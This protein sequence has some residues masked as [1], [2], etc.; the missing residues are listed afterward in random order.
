MKIAIVGTGIAGLG[1]AHLLHPGHDIAVFERNGYPG[2]HTNTIAV[3]E[4]GREVPIDTGFMVFNPVTYPRL[5]RLF[6]ELGVE[7]PRT[8][9]SF[10]VQVVPKR[11]EYNGGSLN[12]LFAQRRNLLRPAHWRMLRQIDRFN[13]EAA[14]ALD[15]PLTADL[16]LG[17]YVERRGY[18]R[19]M[20][21]DYLVPMASAV[22][23]ASPDRMLEFPAA[24]LLRFWLNHGFLGLHTQLAW[25]TV[26]G[27]ARTYVE[28]LTAPFRSRIRL[29]APVARVARVGGKVVVT[30]AGGPPETF[31]RVILAAHADQNLALLADPSDEERN[32][33]SKF[34]Y[35]RNTATLHTDR[36]FMPRLRRCW[37]AWNYRIDAGADGATRPTTHYWMNRLQRVSRDVDYFVSLNCHDRIDP[38]RVLRRIEYEHPLFDREA[39]AAQRELPR[40]NATART[41]YYAGAWFGYGFHEDGLASAFACVQ[42]L[43]E[44]G[45]AA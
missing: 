1:C 25:R 23:S 24:T 29:G 36:S 20:R 9:M 13:R 32:L 39:V 40:L 19:E 43:E 15:D 37:A 2:G 33:L 7:T 31:D 30:A 16:S 11:L 26:A 38:A 10:S 17:Q 18:G 44:R 21:D 41:T 12:L 28:K 5:T 45:R 35:Q 27:G 8:D 4:V 34:R 42:A 14:S 22:W 3:E 6:A